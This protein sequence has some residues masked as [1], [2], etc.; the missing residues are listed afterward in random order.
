[1]DEPSNSKLNS[2]QKLLPEGLLAPTSWLEAHGY[3]RSLLAGYVKRGWLESPA[4]GVYRRPGAPLKWQHAVCSLARMCSGDV[5]VGGLTA[6]EMRGYAHFLK[7]RG[8]GQVA[9]YL[10]AKPPGW[11]AKLGLA[12]RFVAHR[13]TLF[14]FPV[15]AMHEPLPPAYAVR[16]ELNGVTAEPWGSWDDPLPVAL[17]ERAMLEFLDEVP[18]KQ[19]LD[20]AALLMQ[21]LGDL[22]SRRV[23]EL[24]GACRSVK[25]KRLFLALAARQKFQWVKPVLAAADSGAVALGRGKRSLG[26]G[27]RFDSKY[28]ITVPDDSDVR[29]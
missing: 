1:M 14:A 9:L 2:L 15:T 3:S 16:P 19:S 24:L 28:R 25:V 12:E 7:P 26:K 21:G 27:G 10:D 13:N 20:H 8:L 23:L 29:G 4:R 11:L 17:P 22:G 5:H 18:A 6:L